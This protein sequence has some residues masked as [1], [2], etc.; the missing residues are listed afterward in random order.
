MPD[1]LRECA[2]CSRGSRIMAEQIGVDWS[3]FLKNGVALSHLEPIDDAM[4]QVLVNH[5]KT[6]NGVT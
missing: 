3:D 6:K 2:Y 1:D 4:I 5:V